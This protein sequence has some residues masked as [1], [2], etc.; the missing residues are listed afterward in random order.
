MSS[1]R[2]RSRLTLDAAHIVVV[3]TYLAFS[4]FFSALIIGCVLHYRKIVK[5]GVA[6]YP[7]EWFPSVSATIGDWYP[8]RNIFQILI[9]L[10]SGPR[11]ALVFLQYYLQRSAYSS[12]PG[13]LLFVGTLRTLSCGGWVYITSS[14]DHDWHDI[15]MIMYIVCNIPWMFGSIAATPAQNT[16]SRK[17]KQRIAA[18]F[19]LALLPMI[20][21]FIQHKVHRIPGA[22]TRYSF[23]EW[24]LI[25]LDIMFDSVAASDFRA[26]NL[27]ISIGISL[28]SPT[29]RDSHN[30][31]NKA[32]ID[33]AIEKANPVVNGKGDENPVTYPQQQVKTAKAPNKTSNL[34]AVA[35][36]LQPTVNFLCDLY[37]SFVHW[38]VFTSLTPTLFYFSVWE[39]GI[40]GHE[41]SLLSTLSPL[42]L[43]Y[44]VV[45]DVASMKIGRTLLHILTL[46]GLL[47]YA[48]KNPLARLLIV[49]F[50]NAA[51]SIGVAVD[52]SAP[53][54][55]VGYQATITGLG[56]LL[57]SV[58]KHANHS[59]IPIWPIVN[60]A[61][62]GYNKTGIALA[63][64]AIYN[65]YTRSSPSDELPM[66]KKDPIATAPITARKYWILDAFGLG[67]LIF[68]L[69]SLLA[70]PSTLIA[71]SWT[72]Y[73][74]KGPVP[75]LH[76]S[77]THIAQ[78][79][80]L[81]IPLV[82][83]S[84]GSSWDPLTHPLWFVYGGLSTCVMYSYS[85]WLGYFGGLNLTVFLMSIIPVI[86][87]RAA[88]SGSVAKTYS[89]AML[90]VSL[91]YVTSVFTVAYAFVPGGQYF[92]ERTNFILL[93][94]FLLL[95]PA[96][97]WPRSTLPPVTF[98]LS[99]SL[100]SRAQYSLAIM[101]IL[102]LV[103]TVYRWPTRMPQPHRPGPRILRTGIWTVHFGID[104]EGRDSQ[105]RIRDLVRDM[106]LDVF[107]LL[108]TDLHR[109]VFGNRD[110]TRVIVED[111][112]YYVDIGP[113]PNK[114][115]WGAVLFSKFPIINS[116]HHLLPSPHGELAPAIHAVLDVFG[117]PVNVVV[118][119]NGQ[120]ETPL[121]R[122]L[123]SKE[124]ARIM[125]ETYPQPFIFLGYVV[126]KPH[127]PRPAPYEILVTDG[128]M[129]DIDQADLDRWCEYILYRGL[130][131]TAY[132][133][134]SR[135]TITDTELQIGQF[136]LPKY[137]H[138][139]TNE[140]E[141]ARYLRAWREEMPVDH[142]F[143]DEYYQQ[144]GGVRGHY[145]H[146]FNTPLY[147][148]LPEAHLHFRLY[149]HPHYRCPVP[150]QTP[151]PL[152]RY[153]HLHC[154]PLLLRRFQ[155]L[156]LRSPPPLQCSPFQRRTYRD[157]SNRSCHS[158][159]RKNPR[160]TVLW[161]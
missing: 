120:E 139:V 146:V 33:V 45:L 20:Y 12:L 154:C 91:F 21:F 43:R 133:R 68:S 122:E 99:K 4:A 119:H 112:G 118:V 19:W 95:A 6:G 102:S 48:S 13:F 40:A 111:L 134:V 125:S 14:D 142:W 149:L 148:K 114:H 18:A 24:S 93:A 87:F 53:V 78:A 35:N 129:H 82:L 124:V 55:G 11:F 56:F 109:P 54:C 156:L 135:S 77:L 105:R 76:G 50:A 153:R 37:L 97:R 10:N 64:F 67:S 8:E 9:A 126:T 157:L 75:H 83:S 16:T 140:T 80:G 101:T 38:S 121:D 34:N 108:E 62:G 127:T 136:Q 72:G 158:V 42:L 98:T 17:R 100:R 3:H 123:Q 2:G 143:P 47:A 103:T 161:A 128:R 96:F 116:T 60:E 88:S 52:W 141:P 1:R 147:Y 70:D 85:D 159:V 74:I 29:T 90:V 49:A 150:P 30:I 92:R 86:L 115:T 27:Q 137:G 131:R 7:E 106:Q 36:R 81:L 84:L 71:W 41:F 145:Y 94:Q 32:N 155:L 44:P 151:L 79:V 160:V 107:G 51:L 46:F 59:N 5:N 65:I 138:T 73:P 22:Y 152:P 61:S 110:L 15:L 23:F 28:D 66:E 89:I 58:S 104:N 130:Y 144:R 26:A 31:A 63:C 69:H 39:L 113:G 132:A 57:T 25:I 117:T